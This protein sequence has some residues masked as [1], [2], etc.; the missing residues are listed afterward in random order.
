MTT[1]KFTLVFALLLFGWT[2]ISQAQ[3]ISG[4]MTS[5]GNKFYTAD[6]LKLSEASAGGSATSFFIININ[7]ADGL[8]LKLDFKKDGSMLASGKSDPFS[9]NQPRTI[10]N[11]N[12]GKGEYRLKGFKISKDAF[13]NTLGKNLDQSGNITVPTLLPNGLYEFVFSLVNSQN[14]EQASTTLT[15][16]INNLTGYVTLLYP[17][18]P[19]TINSV[20]EIYSFLPT[21]QWQGTADRF[22]LL[23]WEQLQDQ[24]SWSEVKGNNPHIFEKV[25][26]PS[27]QYQTSQNRAL[28]AGKT[29]FWQVKAYSKIIGRQ[30]EEITVSEPYVF[31]VSEKLAGESG[32]EVPREVQ[33]QRI[34][35]L[36]DDMGISP[37][38]M[39]KADF[40]SFSG[41]CNNVDYQNETEINTLVQ[42][43]EQ[44]AQNKSE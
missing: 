38:W 16:N 8:S 42:V 35:D 12:I 15:L 37:D 43:L 29:Y 3:S 17:G 14:I 44:M 39:L 33:L 27:F 21:F 41:T 25:P 6:I 36:L 40:V 2:S 30:S 9:G 24:D 34:K 13:K 22:E 4:Q 31:K 18:S 10:T 7:N 5:T 23:V 28:E 26:A 1:K 19:V 11:N 32:S 20:D